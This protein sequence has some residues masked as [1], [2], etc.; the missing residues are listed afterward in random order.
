MFS[1]ASLTAAQAS[2]KAASRS[3]V[4]EESK[5]RD[6]LRMFAVEPGATSCVPIGPATSSRVL[7]FPQR[8]T[9]AWTL[10]TAG[11]ESVL[12]A[13]PVSLATAVTCGWGP[14]LPRGAVLSGISEVADNSPVVSFRPALVAAATATRRD[15]FC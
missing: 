13:S 4:R 7:P 12:T 9:A 3:W 1:W 8:E 5:L 15:E 2:S 6:L 11:P 10:L 14:A